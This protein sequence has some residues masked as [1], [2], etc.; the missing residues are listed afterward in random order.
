MRVVSEEFFSTSKTRGLVT[1]PPLRIKDS[2][3]GTASHR[4]TS[5]VSSCNIFAVS[6]W[7]SPS[8]H[9]VDNL[10]NLEFGAP[11]SSEAETQARGKRN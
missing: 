10:R 11:D 3:T 8:H 2:W 1:V 5:T 6:D 9:I 7:S 4:G